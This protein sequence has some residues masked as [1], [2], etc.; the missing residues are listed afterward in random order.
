MCVYVCVS[1]AGAGVCVRVCV[2][3]AGVEGCVCVICRQNKIRPEV[4]SELSAGCLQKVHGT[5]HPTSVHLKFS[6]I[7]S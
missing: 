2:S 4:T 7:K 5:V 6:R 1:G 3:G